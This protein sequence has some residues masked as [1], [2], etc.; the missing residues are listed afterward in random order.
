MTRKNREEKAEEKIEKKKWKKKRKKKKEMTTR[1]KKMKK[2]KILFTLIGLIAFLTACGKDNKQE[3]KEAKSGELTKVTIGA[4]E[5]PHGELIKALE[6]EFKK[7]GIDLDLV[8]FSDYV[9]PNLQLES[10]DLDL[11]FYQHQPYLD[12]FN[13]DR[14]TN[15]VSLE[16]SKIFIT[17]LLGFSSKI[18]DI[19]D[20]EDGAEI[21]I[22]N[23]PTNGARA[24]LILDKEGLIK[25]KDKNNLN[26]TEVDIVENPK[27]L[28]FTA[29]D[30]Q[31][32]PRVYQDADL[33]FINPNFAISNGLDPKDAI[34]TE[35]KDSPYANI[36]AARSGE[37]NNEVYKKVVKVLQ[38]EASRKYIE[39]TFKGA[40]LPTF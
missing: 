6:P 12:S 16:N 5:T 31:N 13:K 24:L 30:A 3:V 19:K 17:P 1:R 25:L 9:Q 26:S 29:V 22:P 23:D 11:N 20:L 7:E 39:D 36:V 28:K 2:T 35:A 37:E 40:V 18:K 32:I 21:I 33:A 14:K 38:S 27:N 8:V 4:S 10:G 15:I 34:I